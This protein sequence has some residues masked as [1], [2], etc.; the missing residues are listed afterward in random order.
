MDALQVPIRAA[1]AV[2]DLEGCNPLQPPERNVVPIGF[3]G[4][5]GT[6]SVTGRSQHL[7]TVRHCKTGVLARYP[8]GYA[9]GDA[10]TTLLPRH[11][12]S[13]VGSDRAGSSN[14]PERTPSRA[15][16]S[17]VHRLKLLSIPAGE[18]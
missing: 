18:W 6:A 16:A 12:E 13:G 5:E 4:A 9:G 7:V 2:I 3:G 11:R 14:R 8:L 17:D 10:C 1:I 15:S